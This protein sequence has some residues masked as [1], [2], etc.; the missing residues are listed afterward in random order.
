MLEI[1][2]EKWGKETQLTPGKGYSLTLTSLLVSLPPSFPLPFRLA[3]D[4]HGQMDTQIRIVSRTLYHAQLY[5]PYPLPSPLLPPTH[6]PFIPPTY[7]HPAASHD[8]AYCNPLSPL[9]PVSLRPSLCEPPHHML[10]SCPLASP[11]ASAAP[12]AATKPW[13][14]WKLSHRR[15][16]R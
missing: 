4:T 8:L 3:A 12:A 2:T 5:P 10:R 15:H 6:P 14:A 16:G 9:P 11:A 13:R 1:E 7:L